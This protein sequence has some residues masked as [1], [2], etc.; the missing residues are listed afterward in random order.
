MINDSCSA[1]LESKELPWKPW[2]ER[3]GLCIRF[4][5]RMPSKSKAVLSV[6][7]YDA[8]GENTLWSLPGYHGDGWNKG[9]VGLNGV[10]GQ[11]VSQMLLSTVLH[12]RRGLSLWNTF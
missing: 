6:S 1:A 11:K 9:H 10:R 8:N 5:Y 12:Q 7:R 3:T 2:H 4:L